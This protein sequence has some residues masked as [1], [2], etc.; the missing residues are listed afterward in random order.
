MDD[1]VDSLRENDSYGSLARFVEVDRRRLRI[2]KLEAGGL[3]IFQSTKSRDF[4]SYFATNARADPI[5]RVVAVVD[6][7]FILMCC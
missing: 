6:D 1:A 3:S 7:T 5:T 4:A 2:S